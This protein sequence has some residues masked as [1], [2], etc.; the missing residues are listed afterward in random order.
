MEPHGAYKQIDPESAADVREHEILETAATIRNGE[1]YDDGM[2]CSAENMQ[3]SN[4]L[5]SSLVRLKPP[6]KQLTRNTKLT[7][8][9]SNT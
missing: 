6:K 8:T 9:C 3:L 1:R 2:L 5:S 4:N 7:P